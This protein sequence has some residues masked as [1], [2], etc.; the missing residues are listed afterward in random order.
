MEASPTP[1]Q[2]W[3]SREL[4][5]RVGELKGGLRALP[6]PE[7]STPG[8]KAKSLRLTC[9]LGPFSVASLTHISSVYVTIQGQPYSGLAHSLCHVCSPGTNSYSVYKAHFSSPPPASMAFSDTPHHHH[10][11]DI[12]STQQTVTAKGSVCMS[13]QQFV[14]AMVL[15]WYCYLWFPVILGTILISQVGKLGLG[16]SKGLTQGHTAREWHCGAHSQAQGAPSTFWEQP[17]SSQPSQPC[18]V[19]ELWPLDPTLDLRRHRGYRPGV[20]GL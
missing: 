12:Q 3:S 13:Q 19:R 9:G 2:G 20:G 16:K 5:G 11:C 15:M 6:S 18:M 1:N 17:L 8:S 4:P 7:G 14:L 10:N